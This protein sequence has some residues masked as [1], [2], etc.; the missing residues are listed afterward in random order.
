MAIL[1]RKEDKIAYL[2]GMVLMA[3]VD[4]KVEPEEI[5]YINTAAI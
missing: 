5:T 2:K 1:Q 4:G 3:K